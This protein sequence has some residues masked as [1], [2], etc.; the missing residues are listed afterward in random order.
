MQ[1]QPNQ[2][3]NQGPLYGPQRP[4]ADQPFV[5]RVEKAG[6][7]RSEIFAALKDV[8]SEDSADDA[9]QQAS[10]AIDTGKMTSDDFGRMVDDLPGHAL[11]YVLGADGVEEILPEEEPLPTVARTRWQD[12]DDFYQTNM[13]DAEIAA[14]LKFP[15]ED[16]PEQS[17]DQKAA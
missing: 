15:D 5:A 17:E 9:V 12:E 10:L 1:A 8:D 3:D 2:T 11:G 4:E 14:Q 7:V 13:T 16:K 6:D